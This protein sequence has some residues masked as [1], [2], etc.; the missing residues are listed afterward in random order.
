MNVFDAEAPLH[1]P[2]SRMTPRVRRDLLADRMARRVATRAADPPSDV[3][4]ERVA[5]ELSVA[6]GIWQ[7][8][9]WLDDPASFHRTPPAPSSVRSKPV[10]AGRYRYDRVTWP[11]GYE[12]HADVPGRARWETYRENRIA[13][14]AVL[15]HRGTD[16]PWLIGIHGW[17]M[18]RPLMDLRA[19]RAMHLHRDLGCNVALLTLPLHGSRK[20]DDAGPM[21]GFPSADLVDT[22]HGFEQAVWDTRQL[23][24]WIR[25]YTDQPIG[26]FGQSL[27]GY[28]TALVASLDDRIH[29]ALPLIPAVDFLDLMGEHAPPEEY[30]RMAPL[31]DGCRKVFGPVAPLSFTPKVPVERRFIVAGTLDQ[32]VRPSTQASV[33]WEH[34]D[35]CDMEWFH[36][37]HV[38]LFWAK[39]VQDQIDERLRRFGLAKPLR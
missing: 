23:I 28:T 37:T 4:V 24:S 16:R 5:M 12:P 35:R 26:V 18:G 27:G 2:R 9:G 33:L 22:V 3:L 13:R 6:E 21:S 1:P 30:D 38:G 32:F 17:G 19:L 10:R 36:G 8:N 25:H 34:W 15:R 11:D 14:A 31:L 7:K 20:Q 39:G 29:A